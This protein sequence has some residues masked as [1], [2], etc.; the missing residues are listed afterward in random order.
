MIHTLALGMLLAAPLGAAAP[1]YHDASPAECEAYAAYL[2]KNFKP[3]KNDGPL[4]RR[5]ILIENE[6]VEA[7]LPNRRL[8]ERYLLLRVTGPGRAG[9]AC[10]AAFLA[11]PEQA[12]R[13]FSFPATRHPL[14]LVRSDALSQALSQGWD[15]FYDA[16]PGANGFLSFGMMTIGPGGDEALFT[17]HSQ[18]G[19]RCGYRDLVYMRKVEGEWHV[20]QK[21]SLP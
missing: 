8:W 15:H 11:R 7:R 16:Y 1:A 17:V 13:F 5:A 14:R 10:L 20:V 4:A 12:L 9:D 19:K 21:E 3:S 6:S 2:D 18:C